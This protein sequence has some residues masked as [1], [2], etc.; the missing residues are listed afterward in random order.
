MKKFLLVIV[1]AAIAIAFGITTCGDADNPPA[2]D[3]TY[4]IS[5]DPNGGSGGQTADVTATFGKPMPTL[6]VQPPTKEE[7]FFNGY[8]DAASGGTMYYTASLVSARNWDQKKDATLYA[9]WTQI[10]LSTITFNANGGTGSMSAQQIPENTSENLTANTFTRFGY[11]FEGWAASPDGTVEYADGQSYAAAAGE[12]TVTLYAV[13]DALPP[14]VVSADYSTVSLVRSS[15]A[16]ASDLNYNDI[17]E[18][19][20]EAIKLA[21]GLEG[22]IA[23]GDN[24]V[25]KPNLICTTWGWSA[26]TLTTTMSQTVNGVTT[27]WRVT[28]AVSVIVREIIG[29]YNNNAS[30]PKGRILVMEGPGKSTLN[31]QSTEHHFTNMGYTLTNLTEVQGI[32]RLEDDGGTYSKGNTVNN[33]EYATQVTLPNPFYTGASGGYLDYYKNDGKYWVNKKMLEADAL[34]C[35]PVVKTHWNAAVTGA[36]KNIGIGAAPPKIYGISATDVGRNNMVDHNST[37]LLDWIADYFSVLPADFVVMDGL[38]GLQNGPLPS[39]TDLSPDQK[40]LRC[41]LA[42]RDALAIDIVESNIVGWD[43]AKISY[44]TKLATRGEVFARGEIGKQNPKMIPLRGNAKDIVVLGNVK[45]D[46]VRGD[47]ASGGYG[48]P[49]TVGAAKIPAQET[50]PTIAINT[51]AF[52]GSNLNLALTLSSG[53][54]NNV[55]K[56]DVY[57]DDEYKGSFNTDMANVSLNVSSLA[58]GSHRIEVWAYTAYMFSATAATTAIK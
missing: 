50:S 48:N 7:Y 40:N 54:N 4:T 22:I 36:I 45:I 31:S 58:A 44:L 38:Q 55:V 47:Y 28:H 42:S 33:T 46:D 6:S 14:P 56:I 2:G 17:L 13:W 5:F 32:I 18:L 35:I 3:E 43:Y 49:A 27:D 26:T 29:P 30:A 39:G 41:I 53:T 19:T 57:I 37:N 51:A 25:L 24:V 15:K 10:P 8:W 11:R 52:S 12:N 1:I 21:G 34:I 23:T 9:Q 20:R 16:Q